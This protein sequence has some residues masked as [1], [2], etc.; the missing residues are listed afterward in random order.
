MKRFKFA[1][2]SR[3]KL[4]RNSNLYEATDDAADS[5]KLNLSHKNKCILS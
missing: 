2:D 1:G 5:V 4:L 3:K